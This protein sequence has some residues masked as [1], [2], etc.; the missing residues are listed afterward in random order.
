MDGGMEAQG[1]FNVLVTAAV[2]AAAVL[3][4]GTRPFAAWHVP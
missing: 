3:L 4:F 1:G 2:L